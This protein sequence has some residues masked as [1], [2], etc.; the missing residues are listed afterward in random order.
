MWTVNI[1][2]CCDYVYALVYQFIWLGPGQ[3]TQAGLLSPKCL[4]HVMQLW[5]LSVNEAFWYSNEKIH[6]GRQAKT[7]STQCV[8]HMS[9]WRYPCLSNDYQYQTSNICLSLC[10]FHVEFT[11]IKRQILPPVLHVN[12]LGVALL[13]VLRYVCYGK[14]WDMG[15][16]VTVKC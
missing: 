10:T 5:R 9:M 16:C 4:S 12:M 7:C 1:S 15:R 13:R 8:V 2:F 14:S 11:C 6:E 3:R